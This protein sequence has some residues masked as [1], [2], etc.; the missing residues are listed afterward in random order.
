[1]TDAPVWVEL[2]YLYKRDE[3]VI[4]RARQKLFRALQV[5]GWSYVGCLPASDG[6]LPWLGMWNAG[7]SVIKVMDVLAEDLQVMVLAHEFCH[8]LLHPDEEPPGNIDTPEYRR[9]DR[10]AHAVGETVASDLGLMSYGDMALT[11]KFSNYLT[12]TEMVPE[13]RA[14]AAEIAAQIKRLIARTSVF[15]VPGTDHECNDG[16]IGEVHSDLVVVDEGD[17]D[18][19]T[20]LVRLAAS[21]PSASFRLERSDQQPT[22]RTTLWR[23]TFSLP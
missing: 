5:K 1:M 15:P 18:K 19:A 22:P 7:G 3:N 21:T 14:L 2:A 6:A 8:A 12:P 20:D 11:W 23:A 16:C 17:E 10:I 13:E 4:E 9:E